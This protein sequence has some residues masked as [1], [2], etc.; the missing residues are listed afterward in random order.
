MD[1]PEKDM[2]TAR[3]IRLCYAFPS[4]ALLAAISS[5][6]AILAVAATLAVPKMEAHPWAV[7]F[8][9]LV[10]VVS[11]GVLCFMIVL[12]G[13]RTY[14]EFQRRTFDFS[15]I[16]PLVR[17]YES[18]GMESKFTLAAQKTLEILSRG[19]W[20]GLD[21]ATDV[22]PVLDF[23]EDVGLQLSRN[24]ISDELAHHYFFPTIQAY[25]L[26][27]RD[28]IK[29]NQKKYGKATWEYIEPLY[30]RTF[31]IER[32]KDE[33]AQM[34]PPKEELIELLKLDAE[35]QPQI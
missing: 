3:F 25:Y 19:D 33:D 9:V 22:E 18:A 7:A 28:Y 5:G 26:A 11:F 31:L 15:A 4:D 2:R 16:A 35:K 27:L 17:E 34:H 8:M 6:A 20:S 10:V 13:I 30:E 14:L 29:A 32:K 21:H 1:D 24:Q 12:M 23:L